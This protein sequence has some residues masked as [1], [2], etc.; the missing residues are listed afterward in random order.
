MKF[1]VIPHYT[2]LVIKMLSPN[3]AITLKGNLKQYRG[4]DL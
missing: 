3:G 1:M 2:Y 4:K